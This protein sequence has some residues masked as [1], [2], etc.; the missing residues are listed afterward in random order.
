MSDVDDYVAAL[1]DDVRPVVEEIR[2]RLLAAAPG[3]EEAIKYRM[4]TIVVDGRSLV[5]FAGW[6]R[7]VSLYPAPPD[8]SP[9]LAPLCG[10]KGTVKIPL[11]RPVPYEL[12]T[13]IATKLL[14]AHGGPGG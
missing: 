12:I 13:E 14:A 1:P 9:E 10:D 6:K 2:R 4:P 7:H 5:H 11:D 3:A 8:P